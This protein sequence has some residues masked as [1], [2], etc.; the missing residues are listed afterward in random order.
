MIET[1][2]VLVFL[3]RSRESCES[4]TPGGIFR[5]PPSEHLSRKAFA[6]QAF[7]LS[8]EGKDVQSGR[9]SARPLRVRDEWLGGVHLN[10]LDPMWAWDHINQKLILQEPFE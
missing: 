6:E 8:P 3:V 5:Y 4:C 1:R 10:S 9:R 7:E 2:V